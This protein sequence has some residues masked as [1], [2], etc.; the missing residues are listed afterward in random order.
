M[1]IK[2]V[3]KKFV[4]DIEGADHAKATIEL[5]RQLSGAFNPDHA[6]D[7]LALINQVTRLQQGDL[8]VETF[9][10]VWGIK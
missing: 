8:D 5:I 7:I 9:K 2:E 1:T 3:L 4:D 6:V 10:S